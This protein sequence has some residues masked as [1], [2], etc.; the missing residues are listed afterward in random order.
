MSAQH[1]SDH[2]ISILVINPNSSKVMTEG[3]KHVIESCDL[4]P[5]STALILTAPYIYD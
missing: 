5:V 1:A 2:K 4:A 3:T